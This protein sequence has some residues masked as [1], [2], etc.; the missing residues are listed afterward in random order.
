MMDDFLRD[1]R[2]EMGMGMAA[3]KPNA[4]VTGDMLDVLM[5]IDRKL[6]DLPPI[7]HAIMASHKVPPERT[8]RQWDTMGRLLI[9]VNT[10]L[11]LD[12]ARIVRSGEAGAEG[13]SPWGIPIV[14]A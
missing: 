8:F 1:M 13:M 7:A 10:G 12:S 14:R 9:W 6:R 5:D 2:M 4:N 11:L 3:A